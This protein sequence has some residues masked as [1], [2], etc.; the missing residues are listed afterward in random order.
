MGVGVIPE[1]PRTLPAR[2]RNAHFVFELL[3]RVDVDEYVVAASLGRHAQPMVM[4]IR[5][6]VRKKVP[7]LDPHDVTEPWPQQR[8][9]IGTVVDGSRERILAYLDRLRSSGQRRLED[10]V[11]A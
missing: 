2:G 7:E 9:Q 10:T 5:G 4:Q 6:I 11:A 8:R 1:K 3:A